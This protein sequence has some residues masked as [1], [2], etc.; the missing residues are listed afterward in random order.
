M[1]SLPLDAGHGT[2]LFDYSQQ[3][4]ISWFVYVL[5]WNKRNLPVL[6]LLFHGSCRNSI[7]KLV[8]QQPL[9]RNKKTY[10]LC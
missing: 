7:L 8:S 3:E 10:H 1:F 2:S 5:N 9:R 4:T 6:S